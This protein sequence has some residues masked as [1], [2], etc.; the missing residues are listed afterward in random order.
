MY[1]TSLSN[2]CVYPHDFNLKLLSNVINSIKS[3]NIWFDL[4]QRFQLRFGEINTAWRR[5]TFVFCH[6]DCSSKHKTLTE[7]NAIRRECSHYTA[8]YAVGMVFRSCVLY[9]RFVYV[10]ALHYIV[11]CIAQNRGYFALYTSALNGSGI[12]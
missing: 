10:W 2:N 3:G 11:L 5:A 1:K 6:K 7:F 8:L 9:I 12:T 4:C